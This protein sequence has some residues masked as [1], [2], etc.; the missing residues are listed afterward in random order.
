MGRF[1]GVLVSAI[2]TKL[3]K[4]V[5]ISNNIAENVGREMGSKEQQDAYPDIKTLLDQYKRQRPL[6]LGQADPHLAVH[7]ETMMQ[8]DNALLSAVWP[9]CVDLGVLI[10]ALPSQAMQA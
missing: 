3:F 5:S 1:L 9:R 4:R 7:E 6:S 8:V 10:V 2:I